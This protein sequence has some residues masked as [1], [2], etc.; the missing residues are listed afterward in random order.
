MYACWNQTN[1]SKFQQRHDKS[2]KSCVFSILGESKANN[3]YHQIKSMFVNITISY[4][5]LEQRI[6]YYQAPLFVALMATNGRRII[7]IALIYSRGTVSRI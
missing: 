3:Q 4:I 6:E 1:N 5:G 7:I 2:T